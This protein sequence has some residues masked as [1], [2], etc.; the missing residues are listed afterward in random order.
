MGHALD[1]TLQD[2]LTR[3]KRMQGYSALWLPGSDHASIATEVKVVNKIREEE[4]LE[5]EHFT[6][7]RHHLIPANDGGIALGQAAYAMQYI[8]E[9]K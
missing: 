8:Q 5:K 2:V 6:V 4:G 7:L 9:G 1:Q 3:W